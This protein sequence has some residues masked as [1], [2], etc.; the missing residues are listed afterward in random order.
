MYTPEAF[1]GIDMTDAQ[2]VLAEAQRVLEYDDYTGWFYAKGVHP[3]KRL[4]GYNAAAYVILGKKKMSAAKMVWLWHHKRWP[5]GR[6]THKNGI[7][8]DDRIENLKESVQEQD[9]RR[10]G[11]AERV[12]IGFKNAWQAYGVDGKPIGIYKTKGRT[13]VPIAD[14]DAEYYAGL[15]LF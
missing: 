2:S 9:A 10:E 12:Q 14:Y 7:S 3:R 13:R 4:M 6:V 11:Y 8:T 1:D 5:I 15:D